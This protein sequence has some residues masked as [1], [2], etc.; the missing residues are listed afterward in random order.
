MLSVAQVVEDIVKHKPY[1]SESLAMGL[2]NISAL[3][4]QIKSEV[5]AALKKEVNPGGN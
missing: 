4:R 3:A 5:E 1:L 2:I